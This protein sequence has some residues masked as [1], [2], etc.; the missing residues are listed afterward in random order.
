[1][2]RRERRTRT[3]PGYTAGA[4]LLA[5]PTANA[6]ACG[7]TSDATIALARSALRTATDAL[8]AE[9][10]PTGHWTG[11]LSTSALSTATAVIA[12]NEVC[13]SRHVTRITNGLRWLAKNQN[14]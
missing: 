7:V 8:L 11:E 6:H 13:R 14:A 9:L 2:V 5:P 3:H 4:S 10:G 1:M 12:L